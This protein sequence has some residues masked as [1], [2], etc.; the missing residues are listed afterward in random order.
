MRHRGAE[1]RLE[2]IE[3]RYRARGPL[4]LDGITLAVAP[5]ERVAL[6]GRS[7]CGKSTL[8]QIIA[9]LIRPLFG[10]VCIDGVPVE[11]PSPKWNLM[12][13]RPLL[14]PWLTVAENVGLGLRFA[15]S[16]TIAGRVV[17]LLQLVDLEGFGE[18]RVTELSGGEQQRVALARSLATNPD[19]LLLDEPFSA[20]DTATRT[21]LRAAV[22]R[23]ATE[24]GLTLVLVTHDVDDALQIAQR[25]VRMSSSPGRLV[26]EIALEPAAQAEI[27]LPAYREARDRLI[28]NLAGDPEPMPLT[29]RQVG[30]IQCA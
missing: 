9:G 15:G 8:L 30:A 12:F 11:K 19:V 21:A 14:F 1:I 18:R 13:Q 20:L 23:I 27:G 28:E 25:V 4:V 6:I 3:H 16:R 26:S 5:S 24:L 22:R 10:S 29:R 17:E 7:G 2:T